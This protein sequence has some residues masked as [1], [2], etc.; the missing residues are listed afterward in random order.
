MEPSKA[1]RPGLG[2]LGRLASLASNATAHMKD[3]E[4]QKKLGAPGGV[5]RKAMVETP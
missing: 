5:A 1:I 2:G 3:W 4:H